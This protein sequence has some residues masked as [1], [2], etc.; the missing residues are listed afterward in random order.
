MSRPCP[1]VRKR[2]SLRVVI[3]TLLV[4]AAAVVVTMQFPASAV[5]SG[6]AEFHAGSGV[7]YSGCRYHPYT[8]DLS[9]PEGTT[10]WD[11]DVSL[12]GPDGNEVSSDYLY[13]TTSDSGGGHGKV[14]I[15]A[16]ELAGQYRLTGTLEYT[17]SD[18]MDHSTPATPA[19]FTMRKP[20]TTTK[21]TV[22]TTNPKCG[23]AFTFRV[24]AMDERPN[25]F[26]ATKYATVRLQRYRAGH[27]STI[28]TIYTNYAGKGSST[29]RFTPCTPSRARAVTPATEYLSASTSRTL[30]IR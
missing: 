19:T 13:G 9:L 2:R 7:L 3:T 4:T 5:T 27:W 26:F 15:C 25:G 21:L 24:A 29:F 28:D 6:S 23:Q 16:G 20:R 18:D 22:S 17:G 12:K 10:H 1:A 14:Q 30:T 11:I 8:F